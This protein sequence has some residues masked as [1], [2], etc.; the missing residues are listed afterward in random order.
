MYPV[1]IIIFASPY[2]VNMVLNNINC[3]TG[4]YM[5]LFQIH[6]LEDVCIW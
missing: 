2:K 5:I 4:E 1:D 6:Q 3:Y